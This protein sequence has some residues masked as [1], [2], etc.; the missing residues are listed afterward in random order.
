V[1]AVAPFE[2]PY[3]WIQRLDGITNVLYQSKLCEVTKENG[4]VIRLGYFLNTSMA[5]LSAVFFSNV[6]TY[7]KVI[8]MAK[9]PN[10]INYFV[11][12]RHGH[13]TLNHYSENYEEG[14]LDGLFVLHNPFARYPLDREPFSSR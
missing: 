5:D 10:S 12:A 4:S 1:L 13:S 11:T 2:Q 14:L 8:A 3:F 7:S 9:E 6:A